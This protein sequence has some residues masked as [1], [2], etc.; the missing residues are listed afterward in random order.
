MSRRLFAFGLFRADLNKQTAR[1]L[2]PPAVFSHTRR[3]FHRGHEVPFVAPGVCS[4]LWRAGRGSTR[5][6]FHRAGS[7]LRSIRMVDAG[8]HVYR[9]G[10]GVS[11]IADAE[12]L[13]SR[14][15]HSPFYKNAGRG[16]ARLP[17]RARSVFHRGR[18]V[19]S[20]APGALSVL[21]LFCSGFAAFPQL[22]CGC[23]ATGSQ[24]FHTDL[25]LV[26]GLLD[27]P[28]ENGEA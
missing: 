5:S 7:I 26:R 18:R 8:W 1:G 3:V 16:R 9:S 24:L 11:S 28:R 21:W 14:R 6:V 10:H 13:S 27:M 22:F 4:V 25:L 15:M 23:F 17:F 19:S 12:R 2:F 20:I